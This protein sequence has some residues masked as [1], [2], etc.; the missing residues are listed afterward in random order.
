VDN[1]FCRSFLGDELQR[2]PGYRVCRHIASDTI[3]CARLS[4]AFPLIQ[5]ENPALVKSLVRRDKSP[6]SLT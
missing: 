6:F 5:S 3:E 4:L 1:E 2:R